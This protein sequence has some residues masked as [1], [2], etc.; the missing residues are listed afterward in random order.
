M[1]CYST[2]QNES[3]TLLLGRVKILFPHRLFVS[4][5]W[6]LTRTP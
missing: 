2:S 5:V 4:R 1:A 3:K 6:N